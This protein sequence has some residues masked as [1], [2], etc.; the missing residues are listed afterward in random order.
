MLTPG[1]PKQPCVYILA[2]SR[3]GIL[4]VGVT[5][6]LFGRVSL[7]K[8]DLID[9]FT[10][11]YGVHTLVY[12][13]MHTTMAEAI[14]REKQLKRWN[15]AWKVRLIEQVNPEWTDLWN[16]TGEIR[17]RSTGGQEPPADNLE[18]I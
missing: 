12:F 14:R 16:E 6:N 18:Q 9:G 11:R 8:Q 2:S 7:H 5:S 3:N 1:H 4:Y 13:E 17:M 10:K 15:R